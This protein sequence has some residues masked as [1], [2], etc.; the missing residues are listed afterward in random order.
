SLPEGRPELLKPLITRHCARKFKGCVPSKT[1]HRKEILYP[2]EATNN[3]R[4]AVDL[5]N[6]PISASYLEKNRERLSSRAYL[7][8]ANR[9]W[10]ELWVP[11]DPAAWESPKIVFP[12]IAKEPIFWIDKDGGVVNGE[13]Y[14]IQCD[15]PGEEDLLWLALAVAN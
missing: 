13:C 15:N 7:I 10:Y 8:K 3:G 4:R 5:G 1:K 12:D 14:W 11:Q 6:Y 2:H 9:A